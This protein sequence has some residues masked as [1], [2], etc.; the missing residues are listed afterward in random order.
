MQEVPLEQTPHMDVQA[1]PECPP[2]EETMPVHAETGP[3]AH[4]EPAPDR[5]PQQ[6]GAAGPAGSASQLF[7]EETQWQ[8]CVR[9][10]S[11]RLYSC[12]R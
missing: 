12:W 2:Q 9:L 7:L 1:A 4:K 3:E 11:L 10:S 5:R 6:E 8:N